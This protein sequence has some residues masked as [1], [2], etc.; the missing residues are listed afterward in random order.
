MAYTISPTPLPTV[1]MPGDELVKVVA[2]YVGDGGEPPAALVVD[3]DAYVFCVQGEKGQ[4]YFRQQGMSQSA[5]KAIVQ[6]PTDPKLAVA[7]IT[8]DPVTI[9]GKVT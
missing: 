6:L 2:M 4:R 5:N 3:G 9:S 8:K 7:P 1:Q